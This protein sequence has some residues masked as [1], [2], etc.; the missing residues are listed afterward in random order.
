[1]ILMYAHGI[2]KGLSLPATRPFFGV[3]TVEA[4]MAFLDEYRERFGCDEFHECGRSA[5]AAYRQFSQPFAPESD[6]AARTWARLEAWHRCAAAVGPEGLHCGSR[7]LRGEELQA[8]GSIAPDFFLSR[9]SIRQFSHRPVSPERIERAVDWAV[10]SPSVCNRQAW[11]VKWVRDLALARR[12]QEV[13]G[14]ARGFGEEAGELLLITADLSA[15]YDERERNQAWID[16]GL[17][18]MSMLYALHAQGLGACCLNCCLSGDAERELRA[19]IPMPI[20]EV[21]IARIVTGH[22]PEE[23]RVAISPR[24]DSKRIL[25]VVLRAG[26][27]MEAL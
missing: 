3:A 9:H 22:Y 17:F 25:A 13:A 27:T 16:G 11:R 10:R 7:L 4:L 24:L 15:F 5:L 21:F 1:M 14:G 19:A 8:K 2:E 26:G 23:V 20:T 18:T 6:A 12:I